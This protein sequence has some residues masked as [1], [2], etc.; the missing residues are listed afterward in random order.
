MAALAVRLNRIGE[1]ICV[2]M[3]T[4]GLSPDM[5]EEMGYAHYESVE[6][7]LSDALSRQGPQASVSVMTHGGYTY[8]IVTGEE[9]L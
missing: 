1:R 2:S 5:T 8:P 6:A 3:V 7:A 9:Q 4:E